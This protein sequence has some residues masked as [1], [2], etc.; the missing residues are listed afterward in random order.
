MSYRTHG[1]EHDDLSPSPNPN[2][3]PSPTI[4]G[5]P[6]PYTPGSDQFFFSPISPALPGDRFHQHA[7]SPSAPPPHPPHR[8]QSVA[9]EGGASSSSTTIESKSTTQYLPLSSLPPAQADPSTTTAAREQQQRWRPWGLNRRTSSNRS[10]TEEMLR[11]WSTGVH[12]YV[13]TSMVVVFFLG[14]A[15]AVGHH[16][17]YSHLDDRP[18]MN[19]LTMNRYGTAF[20]FFTKASL[21]GSVVLAYRCVATHISIYIVRVCCVGIDCLRI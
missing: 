13:P 19:Q 6:S 8:S 3:S 10:R 2:R 17:F 18:A 12:W 4:S 16:L 15:G 20:A 21:V 7:P 11:R 1:I 14:C 5:A 9:D